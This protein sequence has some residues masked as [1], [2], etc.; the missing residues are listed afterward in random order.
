MFSDFNR[1]FKP[2]EEQKQEDVTNYLKSIIKLIEC[3]SC[4]T[5]KHGKIVETKM[6]S[7]TTSDILCK[8]YNKIMCEK[9]C[10]NYEVIT[11]IVK[12]QD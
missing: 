6:H 3:K 9:N 12:R 1:V 10:D 7:Y 11:Y 2:T 8:K 4:S 5:C